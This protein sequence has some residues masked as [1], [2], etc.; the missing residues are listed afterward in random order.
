VETKPFFIVGYPRSGTTMVASLLSRHSKVCVPPETQFFRLFVPRFKGFK[1]TDQCMAEFVKDRRLSDLCI[2]LEE[3]EP[4][5]SLFDS[6][7]RM[8]LPIALSIYSQKQGKN[9][10]GEKTPGHIFYVRKIWQAYGDARI[11]GVIRDGRDCV[12]SNLKEEWAG[13]NPQKHA[14]EWTI[15]VREIRRRRRERPESVMLVRY[16]DILQ[17][18]PAALGR[19]CEFVGVEFEMSQL[20]GTESSTTVPEWERSWKGKALCRPD[21]T[22]SYK[23]RRSSNEELTAILSFLMRRELGKFGYDLEPVRGLSMMM[24]I[25]YI[26]RYAVYG[27]VAYPVAKRLARTGLYKVVRRLFRRGPEAS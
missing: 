9:I 21:V 27:E 10:V 13:N 2:T 6:D 8:L 22:N 19:L 26:T 11:V 17:D 3:L 23:W 20:S 1:S 4:H 12:Y 5:R 14:A 16:E 7:W 25:V 24:R 15:A 18:P